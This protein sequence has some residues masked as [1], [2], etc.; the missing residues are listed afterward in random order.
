MSP[1]AVEEALADAR[2]LADAVLYEGYLLYPYRASAQK[3]RLRW[4]FGVLAPR[5]WSRAGGGDPYRCRTETLLEAPLADDVHVRLRALQLESRRDSWD[6][7]V[8]QQVDAVVPLAAAVESEQHTAFAFPGADGPRRRHPVTG[9]VGVSVRV[10]PGP[11]GG[12]RIRVDVEN[13]TEWCDPAAGREEAVRHSLV[14]THLLI[15]L[16]SGTFLS[17][18]DPPEWA[19]P[20]A[21]ECVQE[22]TWPVLLGGGDRP[23]VVLASPIILPD[24][25]EV[26]PESPGD[27]FDA[28]EI[29]EILSLRTLALTDA[30]KAEARATDP[31]AAQIV[32]RL[33]SMP[34]EVWQR[35]H[36][37]VRSLRPT[38]AATTPETDAVVVDGAS[39]SRGRRVR[40]HP[41]GGADAQDMFLAGRAAVVDAVH[42][43]L[44]GATFVAVSLEDD[45][46]TA[47]M[48]SHGRYFYFRP[49]ELE[50]L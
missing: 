26:A 35:L 18:A 36:G 25:A 46:L 49:E 19:R 38:A 15:G 37:A 14:G 30:E 23:T 17:L 28:T 1:A 10:L 8:E 3:N 47:E 16:T 22:V 24:G 48:V 42:R 39:I 50:A 43:D 34:A 33:E 12:M 44:D 21:E 13:T 41:A 5:P 2:R 31:R 29:D 45:P 40:L 7:A 6:E 11:Y 4:Q 27:L 20:A 9:R 32:D